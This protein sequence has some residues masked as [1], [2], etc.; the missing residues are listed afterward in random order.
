MF[1]SYAYFGF[2]MITEI[3]NFQLLVYC[4]PLVAL[5]TD[6]EILLEY[7]SILSLGYYT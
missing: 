3:S 4:Y 1:S 7:L 2:Y 5:R 6:W